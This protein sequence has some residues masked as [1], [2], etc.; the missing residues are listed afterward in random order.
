[1][2]IF[3][4][5]KT[6]FGTTNRV[7]ERLEIHKVPCNCHAI[8]EQYYLSNLFIILSNECLWSK[9][10]LGD[11]CGLIKHMKIIVRWNTK[12]TSFLSVRRRSMAL[13]SMTHDEICWKLKVLV[14]YVWTRQNTPYY[15]TMFFHRS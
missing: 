13:T 6:T 1:M 9:L 5:P 3:S 10:N 2:I 12:D 11:I 4:G 14:G 15:D 7:S 8:T